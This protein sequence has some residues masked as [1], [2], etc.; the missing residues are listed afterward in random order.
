MSGSEGGRVQA[1]GLIK[2]P[3][4]IFKKFLTFA[5][6]FSLI[7]QSRKTANL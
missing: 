3:F 5:P 1:A 4:G 7:A 6:A 2:K